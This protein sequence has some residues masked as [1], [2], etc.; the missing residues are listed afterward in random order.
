MTTMPEEQRAGAAAT[1]SEIAALLGPADEVLVADILRTGAS[2]A[3]VQEAIARLEA[4]DAVGAEARR[5]AS[6]RVVEVMGIL[7]AARFRPEEG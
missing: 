7:E 2:V 3:E 6:A 5:G 4:D 1:A